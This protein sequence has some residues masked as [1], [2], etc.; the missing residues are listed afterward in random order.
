M[1]FVRT[2][3]RFR[4]VAAAQFLPDAQPRSIEIMAPGKK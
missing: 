4:G 2:G 1:Q 3:I